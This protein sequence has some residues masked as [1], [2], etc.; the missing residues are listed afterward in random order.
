[1]GEIFIFWVDEYFFGEEYF[2]VCLF[3]KDLYDVFC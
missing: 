2:N 3:W 1:M